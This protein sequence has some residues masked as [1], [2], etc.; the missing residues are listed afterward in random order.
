MYT[1][2]KDSM[3]SLSFRKPVL[4][5]QPHPFVLSWVYLKFSRLSLEYFAQLYIYKMITYKMNLTFY[6]HPT[7]EFK[8]LSQF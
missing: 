4:E 7:P 1:G 3:I 5:S 8:I 6:T 2:L